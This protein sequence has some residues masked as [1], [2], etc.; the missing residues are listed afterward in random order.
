MLHRWQVIG[1]SLRSLVELAFRVPSAEVAWWGR[2][3]VHAELLVSP[4]STDNEAAKL[5]DRFSVSPHNL[6]N[7]SKALALTLFKV[8]FTDFLVNKSFFTKCIWLAGAENNSAMAWQRKRP[9]WSVRHQYKTRLVKVK[10]GQGT[11]SVR[12]SRNS[13][14][15]KV[16]LIQAG[17]GRRNDFFQRGANC[18]FFQT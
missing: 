9:T 7:R 13:L 4:N 18:W 8:R 14:G 6:A 15:A 12:E 1:S 17:H 11:Q 3:S 5:C 10:W 2:L 16:R